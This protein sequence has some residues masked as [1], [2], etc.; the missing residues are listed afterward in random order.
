MANTLAM[1][2]NGAH[3]IAVAVRPKLDVIVAEDDPSTLGAVATAVRSLGHTCREA[4][5]GLDALRMLGDR[6]ADVIIA[7][8]DMPQ[9]NGA[10]LCERTR[11]AGDEMPYT[12]FIL[13]SAFHDH[14]HLIA[15]MQAGA[16]DYQHKPIDLDE[17]EARLV[18]AARVVKL[19]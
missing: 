15:G 6:H 17:L 7:D 12:Y 4:K 19:H 2:S 18:S 1:T 8:W 9:M 13:M 10:E 14:E 11:N 16:D 3:P 5:D